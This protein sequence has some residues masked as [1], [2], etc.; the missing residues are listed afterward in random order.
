MRYLPALV[1][2]VV[3]NLLYQF[4]GDAPNYIEALERSWFGV[5]TFVIVLSVYRISYGRWPK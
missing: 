3:G 2:V 1:G 4:F 5:W